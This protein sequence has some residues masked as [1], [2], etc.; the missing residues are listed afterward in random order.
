MLI[1][2]GAFLFMTLSIFLAVDCTITKRHETPVDVDDDAQ[3]R[4]I[5]SYKQKEKK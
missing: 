2:F 1:L 5:A 3:L 4:W